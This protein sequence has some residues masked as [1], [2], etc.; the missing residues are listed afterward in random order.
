MLASGL[1]LGA[2]FLC[3]SALMVL[4]VWR[5]RKV[6][7]RLPPG[8]TPLP[9]IG[10]YLQL[11]TEEMFDSLMKIGEEYGPVFTVHLGPRTFIVL[12]GYEAI[13]EA[14]VDQAEEF[15]GRGKLA[16]FSWLIDEFGVAL[17]NGERSRK[18]RRFSITTLRDFGMG[19][20][21]IEERIQE[22]AGFLVEAI[23]ATKGT[24]IDPTFM[25]RCTVSNVICS[26]IFGDRFEYEDKQFLSMLQ[27]IKGSLQ[28]TATSLG[29]LY[30]M[31]SGVMKYLPGP[32]QQA[33]KE[34]KGLEAFITEKVQENQ[35]TLDPNS[36]RNFIDSFLI[37]MQEEKENPNTEF[38]MKNLIMTMLNLFF[39][40][41]ETVGTTLCYG[42][43][44]LMKH[45]EVEAKIHE[46]ID[47]VIG[48]NR[49]PKFEDKAKMPYTDAVIHEIQ[50][51][52]NINPISLV[53]R[54]TK[55]TRFR[56]YLLPKHFLDE[57]GQFKKCDAFIPFSIGKS[58]CFGEGLARME[59]FLSL[60]SMLQNFHIHHPLLKEA[61]DF[62]PT[63]LYEMFSEVMKYLP[64]PQQQAFKE[65]K[66]LE[67]FITEK[68]QE[69][70]TT[71]DPNSPWNFI[72]SF[73][74]KMQ[75]IGEK[76]GPVF[77]VHLGCRIVVVL[78]GYEAVKEA[79]VDQAEEFSGRGEQAIFSWICGDFGVAFSNGERSRQLR[80]FSITTLRDF[81]MGKKGIEERIQE[82][83]GFLVEAIRATKG[84]LIDPTFMLTCTFAN[85]ICSIIFGDR[86]EYEDKQLLSMLQMMKGSLQF[87]ATSMGQLYEM[88]SGV[89]KHLP[90][91][92]QQAFKELKGLEAFI[93][94]KVRQN[95]AT[96]DPNSPRN[97]I[98]SFL[99][100]MQEEKE[101]P[102]TEFFMKN[103]IMTTLN[104]FFA[105]TETVG[106]TLS[107]GFLLLMK[108]PEVEAKIHEEIDQ[109]IGRN[110]LPKF[111][112][113]AKM[114]YTDA[115]I[116]EI[117][118]FGNLN[119]TGMARRVTKDTR[120]RGYLLPKGTDIYPM[121]GS[122]LNDPNFFTCPEAFNPQH[123]LDEK[124]QF[125][126]NDAFIPF[127]IGKRHCFGEGLAKMELFLSLTTILQNF[128]IQS[129]LPKEAIDISPLMVGFVNIPRSYTISFL[130]RG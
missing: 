62:S 50:R 95:Q 45:P 47:Q 61:I 120:F 92:Q 51:F 79:L 44:L 70:Q 32:Q 9:F 43:L 82:E 19:K 42:F 76:Y 55:D 13:K 5:Q 14:L 54:V 100:K 83:A 67:A 93:T 24:P 3:L 81:G 90:G 11:N 113:K 20:R 69:N 121:L 64:G 86:F 38:F 48:H 91:P 35:A 102:N 18:L 105:G 53:R 23:R 37:K 10:N 108:H 63:M 26:I 21:G 22:E 112:D 46:E 116:H 1:L 28:F 125:K 88:F 36:P 72:N 96:L 98:D 75:E 52:G 8:P 4:S 103:L 34:L 68:V 58:Y 124:G 6:C 119:P 77:T 122:V 106:R 15:S 123:F 27:M 41:T 111:E 99:I 89:M 104:L 110:R 127:S 118:R 84:A 74:I 60:T 73:L 114:P 16:T 65:L 30:E 80:R 87:T 97:F 33:F 12:T 107:F 126:K 115:V 66:G 59:L 17:S 31:F 130:P 40:G 71:L 94:E 101:N 56:G 39:A 2:L 78:T 117:Q 49:L 109:V 128:H 25:L 7:S 29:Q 57:K 85:V 129:P